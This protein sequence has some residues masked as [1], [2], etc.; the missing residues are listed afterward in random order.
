ME[1]LSNIKSVFDAAYV[2]W[3][4]WQIFWYYALFATFFGMCIGSF[5]NVAGLRA[6]WGEDIVFMPSRCPKCKKNLNWWNNIPVFSW[7]FQRGKCQFCSCAISPQYPVVEAICGFLYFLIFLFFGFSLK[8]LFLAV[9]VA[10]FIVISITD[11]KER[12]VFSWHVYPMIALGLLYNLLKLG[13][14]GVSAG[15]FGAAIWQSL[16][17]V[18]FAFV[19]FE[20]VARMGYFFAPSRAFGEGDT[21]IA[22]GLG[23][24]FGWK[25]LTVIIFLSVFLQSLAAIPLMFLR[26]VRARDFKMATALTLIVLSIFL[27]YLFNRYEFYSSLWKILPALAFTFTILIW[28]MVVVLK[29]L[30]NKKKEDLFLLPFGPSLVIAATFCIFW[31][32]E[33]ATFLKQL[34]L[35]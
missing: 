11:I 6:L 12:V 10:F 28:C 20:V 8:S 16:I 2:N 9:L 24:F 3:G 35:V 7:V 31:G 30:K 21:L 32:K 5:L 17:G 13:D 14:I 33:I 26:A 27:I 18:A 19:F 1:I 29:S 23:A 4:T 15:V 22:M 25:M 34:I